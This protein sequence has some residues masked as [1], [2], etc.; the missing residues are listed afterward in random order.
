MFVYVVLL[1]F[2]F[3]Q[4]NQSLS[5]LCTVVTRHPDSICYKQELM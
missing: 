2:T 4:T 1:G 3:A 5:W